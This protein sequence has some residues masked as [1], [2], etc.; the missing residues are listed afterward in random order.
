M[1]G[2]QPGGV[3]LNVRR[4]A[5]PPACP[6]PGRLVTATRDEQPPASGIG[7]T[8]TA[9]DD[10][11]VDADT[12]GDAATEIAAEQRYVD[13]VYARLERAKKDAAAGARYGTNEIGRAHV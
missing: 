6:R 7:A 3:L 10:E 11:A 13:R 1:T 5:G 9:P 8:T 4:M 12:G 2:T